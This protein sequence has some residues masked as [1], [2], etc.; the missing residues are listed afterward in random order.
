M[1][2]NQISTNTKITECP[3]FTHPGQRKVISVS[4]EVPASTIVQTLAG[5][6]VH[7]MT[8]YALAVQGM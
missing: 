5:D 3:L 7:E 6:D 4:Q 1:C 2:R 8:E